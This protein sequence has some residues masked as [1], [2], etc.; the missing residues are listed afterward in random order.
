MDIIDKNISPKDEGI[1]C[2]KCSR[3]KLEYTRK[4]SFCTYCN[5]RTS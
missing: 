5:I 2:Q 1:K 4:K 3:K